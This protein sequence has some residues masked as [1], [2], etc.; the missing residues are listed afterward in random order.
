MMKSSTKFVTLWALSQLLSYATQARELKIT[1]QVEP[2]SSS[3]KLNLTAIFDDFDFNKSDLKDAQ[4]S[5]NSI[6]V[7]VKNKLADFGKVEDGFET[8]P[9]RTSLKVQ[10]ASINGDALV[11]QKDSDQPSVV[12]NFLRIHDLFEPV[13]EEL[14]TKGTTFIG[15]SVKGVPYVQLNMP[16]MTEVHRF[17]LCV[18][19]AY[20]AQIQNE[21]KVPLFLVGK[22]ESE[23]VVDTGE[24]YL[25]N[26][27]KL[28]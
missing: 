14:E 25:E 17:L 10:V 26:V 23:C 8:G 28:T 1:T 22:I 9:N 5:A 4:H 27:T 19:V 16:A 11:A 15:H 13:R 21:I 20:R 6:Y 24:S 2:S 18:T 7:L 12:K 3:D